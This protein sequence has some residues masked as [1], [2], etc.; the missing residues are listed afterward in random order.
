[1]ETVNLIQGSPEWLQFRKEHYPASE[2]PAMMGEA[3]YEPKTPENL[4]LT[5][6]GLR[7]FEVSDYQQKIFDDGHETEENAR[8]LVEQLIGEPLA[9]V[10]CRKDMQEL[11]LGLSASLD[12]INFGGDIIFEHKIWNKEIAEMIAKGQLSPYYTWQL[13]Q[14]LF[15]SGAKKVIF[16]TSDSFKISPEDLE[17]RKD[18]LAMYSSE[19]HTADDGSK[20][21]YAANDFAWIQYTPQPGKVDE[22]IAGWEKFEEVVSEVLVEDET[23][24]EVAGK[25]LAIQAKLK[26]VMNEKKKLED[27]LKPYKTSLID[28]VKNSGTAKMV[29][30]GVEVL[31]VERKGGFDEKLLA[32]FL[33]PEQLA[34]CRKSNSVSWQVK[35]SKQKHT[36]EQ[37]KEAKEAQKRHGDRNIVKAGI[38]APSQSVTNA[39]TFAF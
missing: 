19:V 39:G 14:Q 15:V 25:F 4:A 28:T 6:L 23:W 16:V 12:G 13:E 2:A 32:Q 24:D 17:A 27:S 3:K 35:A 36:P 5:R 33:T 20:F 26:A 21:H 7:T 31:Q 37:I 10:T 29:G 18:E 1:M 34:Q 30:S 38:V 11:A 9:N 8:P 22:L